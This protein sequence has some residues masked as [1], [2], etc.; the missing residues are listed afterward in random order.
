MRRRDLSAEAAAIGERFGDADLFA[1]AVHQQGHILIQQGETERGLRLLD[2]AMVAVTAGEVSPIASGLVYCGVI[3]GCQDAYE[4]RRAQEW[5]AALTRWCEQQA[6]MVAFTRPLPRA[7]CRAA[8]AA[9]RVVGGARGGTA[10]RRALRGAGLPARIGRGGLPA[11]RGAPRARR[12]RRRG[13]LQG[14][15]PRRLRAPAGPRPAAAGPGRGGPGGG[16]HPAGARRDLAAPGARAAPPGLRGDPVGGRRRR[17]GG[18][19]LRG[20]G[21]ACGGP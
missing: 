18:C 6:G 9:G 3:L 7:P 5:T 4:M 11:R 8:P 21:A 10:G 20:A 19:G 1:L 16:R 13:R 17:G 15:E 14:G 12:P 2:E